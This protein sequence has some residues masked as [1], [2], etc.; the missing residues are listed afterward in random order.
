MQGKELRDIEWSPSK[1]LPPLFTPSQNLSETYGP[2]K[3]AKDV[4]GTPGCFRA[5][6]FPDAAKTEHCAVLREQASG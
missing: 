4:G 2:W 6:D 1:A 5:S 3:W